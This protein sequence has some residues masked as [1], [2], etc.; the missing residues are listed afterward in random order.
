M[1]DFALIYSGR[2][3]PSSRIILHIESQSFVKIILSR[4]LLFLFIKLIV[5]EI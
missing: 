4:F 3:I 5:Y 1:I 2:V